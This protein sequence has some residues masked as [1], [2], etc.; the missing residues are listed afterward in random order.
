MVFFHGVA[1]PL[2]SPQFL[3]GSVFVDVQCDLW[4]ID[5]DATCRDAVPTNMDRSLDTIDR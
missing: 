2:E 4:L 5:H 3:D 1:L